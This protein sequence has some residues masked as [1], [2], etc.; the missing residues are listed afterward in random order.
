M[1]LID[2]PSCTK[3]ISD[4][5]DTCQHCGF[6]L[7]QATDEDIVRK[8][9]LNRFKKLNSIQTQSMI[10]MLLFVAGFAFMYWGGARQDELHYNIAVLMSVVGF[11]WYIVNRIRIL[12]IKRF[13]S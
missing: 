3:K 10:A 7:G 12:I 13:S 5:A 8:K 9:Q 6:N 1:A 2:C 11:V 4:K